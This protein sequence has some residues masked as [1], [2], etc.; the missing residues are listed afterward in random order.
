[1]RMIGHKKVISLFLIL[2]FCYHFSSAYMIMYKEQYYEL[3][4]V[5][6]TNDPDNYL[7]NIYWLERAIEADF[8]NPLYALAKIDNETTWKKYR[9]LFMM[10]L[11]L[12]MVEQHL[13]LGAQFDKQVAYFYNAPWKEQ[14]IESLQIAEGYYYAALEYWKEAKLW[15]EQA[16]VPSLQFIYVREQK[17]WEENLNRIKQ[18][19]LNYERIIRREIKRLEDVREEF[20]NMDETT[21]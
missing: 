11:N 4:H 8:C 2:I 1:M 7:E 19:E 21:Y 3:Y 17:S 20:R 18:G 6:Y 12:K 16:S 9:L 13:R 10:H 14:N 15:A 5:H